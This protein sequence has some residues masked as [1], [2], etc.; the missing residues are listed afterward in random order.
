VKRKKWIALGA[1]VLLF[2]GVGSWRLLR[3]MEPRRPP[4]L[5]GIVENV[6][7][8]GFLIRCVQPPAGVPES[9]QNAHERRYSSQWVVTVRDGTPVRRRGGGAGAIGIGQT[10]SVWC[11]GPVAE[12]NPP[13][14]SADFVVV[15]VENP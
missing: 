11:S 12:S 3:L 5:Y 15:D 1:F 7:A 9:E 8:G 4:E 10:V 2:L 13:Q 14:R 6:F